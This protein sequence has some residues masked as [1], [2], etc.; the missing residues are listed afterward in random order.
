MQT[1]TGAE[2]AQLQELL[3]RFVLQFQDRH[4]CWEIRV[5]P[6]DVGSLWDALRIVDVEVLKVASR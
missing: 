3:E 5:D 1:L 4:D 2:T 6:A